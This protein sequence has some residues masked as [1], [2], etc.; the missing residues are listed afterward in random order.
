L[1]NLNAKKQIHIVAFKVRCGHLN[2]GQRNNYVRLESGEE[3]EENSRRRL[4]WKPIITAALI[5][6]VL[7]FLIPGGGPWISTETGLAAMGRILSPNWVVDILGQLVLSL[8]Y[9]MIIASAIYSLSTGGGIVL[10][11]L[12]GVPLYA[13]NWLVFR[14]LLGF[15]ANELHAGI[16]H[17]VFALFFSVVYRAAAVP[18]PRRKLA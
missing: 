13:V 1:T 17:L 12:L 7:T 3:Q 9:G 2:S 18:P 6:G 14:Q 11:T 5:A 15:P 4:R 10:G 16:T 8:A